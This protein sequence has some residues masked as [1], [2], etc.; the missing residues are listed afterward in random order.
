MQLS[1][2][3]CEQKKSCSKSKHKPLPSFVTILIMTADA[4]E[5]GHQA[6][7]QQSRKDC[8]LGA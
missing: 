5:A 6:G 3:Y 8:Y 1:P 7:V 4:T 2:C